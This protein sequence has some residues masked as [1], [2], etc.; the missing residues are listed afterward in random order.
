[1]CHFPWVIDHVQNPYETTRKAILQTPDLIFTF[2]EDIRGSLCRPLSMLA[3]KTVCAESEQNWLRNS[4]L[5][6][7][8]GG[9]SSAAPC[10]H[11]LARPQAADRTDHL[12]MSR[13]T[14]SEIRKGVV[15]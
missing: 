12:Q 14:A 4:N 5:A 2:S 8:Y 13:R 15:L 7:P 3:R 10:H 11:G 1:M 6:A 9:I